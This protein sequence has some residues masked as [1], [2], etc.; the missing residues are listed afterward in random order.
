MIDLELAASIQ[1]LLIVRYL[2][3]HEHGTVYVVY[4]FCTVVCRDITEY[5]NAED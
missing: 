5:L 3:I 1:F 2:I 4:V